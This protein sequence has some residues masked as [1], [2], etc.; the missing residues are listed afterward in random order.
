MIA[1][2][3]NGERIDALP[4][5]ARSAHYSDGAFTT[6]RVHAGRIAFWPAHR[7]RLVDACDVLHLAQPD[8]NVVEATLARMV[9]MHPSCVLKLA[10]VPHAG[11]RGYARAWPS[12]CDVD[13][14]VH[15]APTIDPSTY[16]DGLELETQRVEFPFAQDAGIK[17]LSR[18]DQ[19]LIAPAATGCDVLA[20]D[21]DGF[22]LGGQSGNVFALFGTTWATP[23]TGRGVIAGV[24][25]S[26]LLQSPPPG[27]SARVQAMHR[28]AFDHADAVILC[29]AVRGV[30]PARRLDARMLRPNPGV[31]ALM[32]VFHP[33]LGL[34]EA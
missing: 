16:R 28:D 18:L 33:E 4:L 6:M 22:V 25:R 21:R 26:A 19:V 12:A 34:P 23:P 31:G 20:C 24:M 9:A 27:F 5:D 30:M 3:R 10:L 13:L 7:Q 2:F 32:H 1:A 17:T 14:F 8:W 11:G 15:D 29:N